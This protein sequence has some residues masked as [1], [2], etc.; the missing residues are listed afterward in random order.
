MEERN[1]MLKEENKDAKPGIIVDRSYDAIPG[2]VMISMEKIINCYYEEAKREYRYLVDIC[3]EED[4][5]KVKDHI[6]PHM[7][8][9]IDFLEEL[10]H[11]DEWIDEDINETETELSVNNM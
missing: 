1:K 6:F 5:Q 10:K 4:T 9:V 11:T 3:G 8:R 2:K 7:E